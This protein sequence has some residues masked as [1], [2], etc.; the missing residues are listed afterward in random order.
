MAKREAKKIATVA[1]RQEECRDDGFT[2][3]NLSKERR[4]TLLKELEEIK[5]F[6]MQASGSDT[7]AARLLSFAADLESEV[8]TK[9]YGLVFEEHLEKVDVALESNLPVLTEDA[10]RFIDNGGGV[11]F[12][13]EGDNLAALKLLEKTHRGKI[14]FIYID[15]PYNTGNKDFIYND[16]YVDKNDG[17]RHSKWLSFMAKRLKI[18][19]N[20]LLDDGFLCVSIDDNELGTLRLL[21][22]QVFD[23]DNF[24]ACIP[25][26][27][28]AS[29][30]TTK[31]ISQN[32]DYIVVYARNKENVAIG[33]LAHMDPGFKHEDEFVEE[34]G[35]YKLNQTL[36][37]DSLQYSVALDYPIEIEG[38][39]FYPGGDE[40]A[41][42]IRMD[43]VHKRADWA[44]RWSREKF[45]FG[46]RNG[47]VVVKR[48][49]DGTAR[50]YTKTYLN[51]SI[52]HNEDEKRY[53]IALIKRAKPLST[54]D[55]LDKEFS[56][57]NAKKDLKL[58]F[59]DCPFDYPKPV[60]L[61]EQ[62]LA[63]SL[64]K[65]AIV[66]DFF[67]GS[68]TTGHAVMKLN[69]EDGGNRRFILVTNN[70]NGICEKVTYE[71]LK[72]VID[73]EKYPARLKYFKIGY[74]P[75]SEKVYEEYA[76][77][78]LKHVKELVELENGLD[79]QN[80]KSVAIVLTD[81]DV[82]KLVADKARL[83]TCKVLYKGHDVL[84]DAKT[85]KMLSKSGVEVRIIPQY[86]Y[87]ELGD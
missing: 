38:E 6:L 80:D 8:S 69:A 68:G 35:R 65:N 50:I 25:R 46:L 48:K 55:F 85:S 5:K 36:D 11:N 77:N 32:H 63:I 72:R 20:L 43:G 29:G 44:W 12:L 74:E 87:P 9:K 24:V 71:R 54:I 42:R 57:D 79:F 21:C 34:R 83:S 82:E 26:R 31:D 37:Y 19:R 2:A 22:D 60:R 4:E 41:W 7:N 17:F 53:E 61:I 84:M 14:D 27:T 33:G 56:N 62:L 3:R 76:D 47:F 58:L 39:I 70:E 28:K 64:N 86:Y 78:L 18:A 59:D 49:N 73:K 67:A 66:L 1:K 10:N 81:D 15:P 40:H 75:I 52:V 16:S 13:I 45:D 23:P 51:A 30:K